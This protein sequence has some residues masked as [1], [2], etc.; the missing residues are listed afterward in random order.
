MRAR[1][2]AGTLLLMVLALCANISLSQTP[3]GFTYQAI[4]RNGS[5]TP[6]ANQNVSL[7]ITLQRASGTAYYT[8]R[9]SLTS[10]PQ[11]V[12]NYN[13]GSGVATY[14]QFD[15]IP[16][17]YGDFYIKVEI[18]PTGG[19][20]YTQMGEPTKIESVPYALYA[21]NAKEIVSLSTAGD[22]D[23]IFV[24]RNKAGQIVFAVYQTG[25]RVYVEDSQ[26]TKGVRGGF[27]I[28]GL[29]NQSKGQQEY[30]RITAD[31]AR[32]YVKEIPTAKGVRGGFAIGG[33]TNQ[34]KTV[35]SRNL[36][37][38]APDSARIW[39]NETVTKGVRGGFAIGG[40]TNQSKSTSNQFLSLTP[41]NY[42]IGHQS[43]RLVNAGLYNSFLGY[44]TGQA[45]TDGSSNVFIGYESGYS[46]QTG[47]NNVAVGNLSGY[48]GT[49]SSSN[50]LL[51]DSA[52]YGNTNSYNVFIGKGSGKAN[53]GQ[54]NAFMGYEAGLKNTSGSNN[55]FIGN[56]SGY[57]NTTGGWN[58]FLGF[59]TGYY[60]ASNYNIFVGYQCGRA[61]TS[62]ANN[63]FIGYKAGYS[64]QSNSSNVFI[65]NSS[66]Y[67]DLT[68]NY[69]IFLGY[70]AGYSN[71]TGHYNVI[72]GNDAGGTAV[73]T[74]SCVYI[75]NNAAQ[76]KSD[77]GFANV[78]VGNISGQYNSGDYNTF[79]GSAAGSSS[80]ASYSTCIG[81]YAGRGTNG[82]NNLFLGY[83][84]GYLLG[85]IAN[86]V[87]LGNSSITTFFCQGAYAS[88]TTSA[89]NL[90]V[91]SSGQ[92][93]RSTSS[94]RYKRDI[95][96]LAI[97]TSLIYKLRPVS[98]ISISENI[99]AF[100]LIAE[101]VAEVIPELAEF[102]V[103]KQVVPGS[104][105]DKL[106]PDAVKYPLLSVLLLNEVQKHEQKIID[107]T[108]E[109]DKLRS[110]NSILKEQAEKLNNLQSNYNDLKAEL[111]AI[112]ALINK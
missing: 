70:K 14:G 9:K 47:S 110:E 17:R 24:V 35:T 83:S 16:W 3:Q 101:E 100:G 66:G 39:V 18:D 56:K 104:N 96:D 111:E 87:V 43:G 4:I 1:A 72:I 7:Q 77:D 65:G 31:S 27:A 2:F 95:T 88:T 38:V 58:T 25:V 19:T 98:F 21:E 33:L 8:E 76:Y 42:F 10:N 50:V 41:N 69:N 89:A 23:P 84:A 6:I 112:K 81:E 37:F 97:N 12:V 109:V 46:N 80:T 105:S 34:S 36:M 78:Y 94:M 55:V 82:D 44:Q 20:T 71:T 32:I 60:N 64:H 103:E 40:L 93:M 28:G 74:L 54:Y 108:S 68:G 22:D 45:T 107:L 106:I 15:T 90:Y 79:V 102:A 61:N 63:T 91:N 53:T 26:I 86:R 85:S 57:S 13:I 62:G 48:V 5:G 73:N 49:T 99:P 51:G 92:I 30:F 29:T 75:G 52:G 67:N 59:E 11:G